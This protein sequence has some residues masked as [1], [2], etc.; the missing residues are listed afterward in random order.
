MKYFLDLA[1]FNSRQ[2]A[3]LLALAGRLEQHPDPTALAGRIAALILMDRSFHTV[4]SF[5]T[6]M[7]RLGGECI[8]LEPEFGLETGADVPMTHRKHHAYEVLHALGSYTDVIGIRAHG[9]C[10]DLAADLRE[11]LFR[12]FTAA[13]PKPLVNLGSAIHHPCQGLADLKTLDDLSIPARGGRFVLSW[14]YDSEPRP[15]AAAATALQVAASRGMRVSVHAPDGYSIPGPLLAKAQATAMET[16]GSI[17]ET[18]DRDAATDAA[19]VIYG[20]SWGTT[21]DYG[22]K[23]TDAE[24]RSGLTEWCVDELWFG[25]AQE[26]CQYMQTLPLRR[27]VSVTADVLE[28]PRSAVVRQ[29]A[30][31]VPIQMAILHRMILG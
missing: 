1:G 21:D 19:H 26:T 23:D 27:E 24:L 9:P 15:L 5:Q 2:L 28:G 16:G 8:V 13:C 12:E 3:D 30:N 11:Q 22:N 31:R 6:A 17:I 4:S 14:V 7:S 20:A 25:K 18:Q 10:D 29:A